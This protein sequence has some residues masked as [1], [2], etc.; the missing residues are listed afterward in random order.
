VS[1]PQP[2][3]TAEP[4]PLFTVVRGAPTEEE[5]AALVAVLTSRAAVVAASDPAPAGRPSGWADRTRAL[6]AAPSPG[7]GAWVASARWS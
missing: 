7:P 1:D 3:A 5:L 6:G 4:A 2:D